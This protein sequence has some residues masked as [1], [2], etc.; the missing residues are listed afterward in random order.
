ITKE[1]G[2]SAK[3]EEVKFLP[4]DQYGI[5]APHFVMYVKSYLEEKYGKEAIESGGYKVITTLDWDLQEKAEEVVKRYGPEIKSK[6]NA[7]NAGVVIIDP[8]TGHILAMV[9]SV[10]YFNTDNDGNF[11]ITVA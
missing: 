2:E 3:S 1:E 10:D 5:R 8:K 11:N 9:G 4:P 6:F 7:N